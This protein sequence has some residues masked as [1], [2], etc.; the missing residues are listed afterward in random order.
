MLGNHDAWDE[1]LELMAGT[2]A[3]GGSMFVENH[4]A[5]PAT[6][7]YGSQGAPPT[8]STYDSNFVS[9]T[10]SNFVSPTHN[11]NFV[12]STP[13]NFVSPTHNSNFV[14]PHDSNFVSSTHDSNFVLS[15]QGSNFVM[16]AHDSNLM[17]STQGSN[18]VVSAHDSNL[19]SSQPHWM[20]SC[21]Y[22]SAYQTDKPQSHPQ[23]P[24]LHIPPALPSNSPECPQL[25]VVIL[26]LLS[27]VGEDE[28][29]VCDDKHEYDAAESDTVD[30]ISHG[31]ATCAKSTHAKTTKTCTKATKAMK[32]KTVKKKTLGVLLNKL[33]RRRR[34]IKI[35]ESLAVTRAPRKQAV[36]ERFREL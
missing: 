11:S 18:F 3:A 15:T 16:S 24:Q 21:P 6:G 2:V 9:S 12:S 7:A 34:E 13:S 17:S 33:L 35:L 20:L 1:L 4:Y 5:P 32:D 27:S 22:E 19:V 8:T 29:A 28:P 14:L 10:P 23:T 26:S 31:K 25:P 30:H 36:P